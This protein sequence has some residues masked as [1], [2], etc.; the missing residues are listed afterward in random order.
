MVDCIATTPHTK[1]DVYSKKNNTTAFVRSGIDDLGIS[2]DKDRH[3]WSVT[4]R[5][6]FGRAMAIST[7]RTFISR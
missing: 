5:N 6:V 7:E 1:N 2:K 4:I 3:K